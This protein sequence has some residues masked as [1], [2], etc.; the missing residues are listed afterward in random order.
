MDGQVA[1]DFAQ[2]LSFRRELTAQQP[3]L[4]RFF[5]SQA[6]TIRGPDEPVEERRR[7]GCNY[8]FV[9]AD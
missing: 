3:G 9:R 7:W 4:A 2:A 5:Q 6:R 8:S 1:R